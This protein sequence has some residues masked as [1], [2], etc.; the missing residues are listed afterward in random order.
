VAAGEPPREIAFFYA[1]GD[2]VDLR[3]EMDVIAAFSNR[4]QI[5]NACNGFRLTPLK[6]VIGEYN[7]T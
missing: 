2:Y 4:P 7:P 6:A 5:H 3:A 1:V